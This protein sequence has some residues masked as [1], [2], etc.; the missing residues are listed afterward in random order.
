MTTS[1]SGEL[2]GDEMVVW[3]RGGFG[4]LQNET[5]FNDQVVLTD[6]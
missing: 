4:E 3:W 6:D 1:L 2:V 5:S